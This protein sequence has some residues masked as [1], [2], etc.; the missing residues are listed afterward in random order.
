MLES[1]VPGGSMHTASGPQRPFDRTLIA[2]ASVENPILVT[3]DGEILRY[4]AGHFRGTFLMR[5]SALPE[6]RFGSSKTIK[7]NGDE[8]V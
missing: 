8:P 1:R 2:Q 3:T 4:A 7:P 5:P 6:R